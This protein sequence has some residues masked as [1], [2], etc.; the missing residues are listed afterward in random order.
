[1]FDSNYRNYSKMFDNVEDNN[2]VDDETPEV[3]ILGVVDCDRLNVRVGP[4]LDS[5]VICEITKGTKVEIVDN[6]TYEDWYEVYIASGI[7]GFCMRKFIV[8]I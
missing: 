8:E 3:L 5:E 6:I 1:M 2:S 7:G 4:D